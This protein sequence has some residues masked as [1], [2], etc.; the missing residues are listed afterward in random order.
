MDEE[1]AKRIPMQRTGGRCEPARKP[2]Y[3][4]LGAVELKGK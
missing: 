4:G 2:S 3:T 1:K